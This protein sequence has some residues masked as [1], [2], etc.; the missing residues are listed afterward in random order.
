VWDATR[1]VL[2]G[3][4]RNPADQNSSAQLGSLC[5]LCIV[6]QSII[7]E[8]HADDGPEAGGDS[9]LASPAVIGDGSPRRTSGRGGSPPRAVVLAV[10]TAIVIV[11][12]LGLGVQALRGNRIVGVQR[13][14]ITV[15]NAAVD[16]AFY[17]CLDIQTRSL[18][19]PGEPI[20]L[21]GDLGDLVTMIKGVGSWVTIANPITSAKARLSL[22]NN[23]SGRPAC[24]GTVVVATYPLA[25]GGVRVRIGSGANVP[26]NG[27]P[28][29][30]PL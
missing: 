21:P 9:L 14:A 3:R 6:T 24:L 28:P 27:P 20:A 10:S 11:A 7:V 18:V 23:V 8:S 13:E 16:N 4:G 1:Q 17:R 30:P 25:G 26:G 5:T 15:H 2:F 22:R 29:A 19:K 12:A